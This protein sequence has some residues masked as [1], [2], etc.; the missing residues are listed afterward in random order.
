MTWMLSF[1]A[2]SGRIFDEKVW[3][4]EIGDFILL[5]LTAI[6]LYPSGFSGTLNAFASWALLKDKYPKKSNMVESG[7]M[8]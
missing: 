7:F 6:S 4:T 5:E 8:F 1:S 2:T 3:I